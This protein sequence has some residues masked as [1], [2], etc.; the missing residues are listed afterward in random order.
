MNKLRLL[1]AAG[2]LFT[3]L[4]NSCSNEMSGPVLGDPPSDAQYHVGDIGPAGGYVFYDKGEFSDGWRYLEAAPAGWSGHSEDPTYVFGYNWSYG[5]GFKVSGTKTEVGTGEA[6]TVELVAA[7][8]N[9][10]YTDPNNPNKTTWQ[11]AAKICADYERGG[12]DD[13]FLPSI[14][15]LKLMYENL[16]KRK[17]GSFSDY[18]YWSSSECDGKYTWEQF[19][20]VYAG[21]TSFPVANLPYA[22]GRYVYGRVKPLRAF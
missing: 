2:L 4:L 1:V 22:S 5:S 14:N 15:E 16:K 20:Y 12:Y 19:F 7:M 21:S 10:A 11:Y 6:N 17:Q 3:F 9:F 18:S 13:W 8:G